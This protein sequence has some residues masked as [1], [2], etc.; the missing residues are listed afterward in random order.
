MVHT[1]AGGREAKRP[2]GS[3]RD[4]EDEVRLVARIPGFVF[5]RSV[6]SVARSSSGG[7]WGV[8][9]CGIEHCGSQEDAES[10]CH[11]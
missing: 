4:P 7:A 2:R 6:E 5:G 11:G 10:P 3:G 9:V 8:P 1:G